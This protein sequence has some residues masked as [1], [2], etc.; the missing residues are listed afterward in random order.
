MYGIRECDEMTLSNERGSALI[1]T[2]MLLLILTAIGIYA[3]SISTTE[4]SIALQSKTGTA[5]LNSAESG[6]SLGI[7]QIPT[8]LTDCTV[9][10]PG[11][12]SYI[13]TTV[14][15]PN[16]TIRPGYGANF[17]FQDFNVAAQGMVPSV[18]AGS[19]SIAAVVIYGPQLLGTMY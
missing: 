14:A 3:I 1:I 11:D 18:F 15:T 12:T 4:M 10:L 5:M 6:A 19:R 9:T 13:V 16:F 8:T 17:A 2:M 7:D